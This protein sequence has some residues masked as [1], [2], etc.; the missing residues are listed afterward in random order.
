MEIKTAEFKQIFFGELDKELLPLGFKYIKSQHG[1]ILKNKEN[2]C[3]RFL[4][5]CTGWYG[6]GVTTKISARNLLLADTFDKICGTQKREGLRIWGVYPLISDF[7]GQQLSEKLLETF[8]IR[9]FEEDIL[10][11]ARLWLEYFQN[12]GMPFVEKITTDKSFAL[13]LVIE[14]ENSFFFPERCHYLPIMY[15]QANIPIKDIE[16]L[17]N[18]LEREFDSFT[19]LAYF[20]K[21][22]HK[23][24]VEEYYKVKDAIIN[25]KINL[26]L[27]TSK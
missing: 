19:Q 26:G 15:K 12:I 7:L 14:Y 5:D 18:K 1:Y 22:Y 9:P 17:C 20:S 4:I 21:E 6:K 25:G 3:F 13:K 27:R 10:R 2:W 11:T 8:H 16:I 24:W 23:Q